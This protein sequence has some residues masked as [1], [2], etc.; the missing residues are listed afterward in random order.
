MGLLISVFCISYRA[1]IC[2]DTLINI[3]KIA[4]KNNDICFVEVDCLF[5]FSF[6]LNIC[7]YICDYFSGFV[8]VLTFIV[9]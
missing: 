2:L 4:T 5:F 9:S 3:K 6:L 7:T 8:S 1:N